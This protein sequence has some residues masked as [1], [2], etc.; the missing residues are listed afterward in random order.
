MDVKEFMPGAAAVEQIRRDLAVYEPERVKAIGRIGWRVPLFLVPVVLVAAWLVIVAW[1]IAP[2]GKQPF[3][4]FLAACAGLAAGGG[5]YGLAR[6]PATDTQ[7]WLRDRILPIAFGF[8][9]D[10]RYG[11][12]VTPTSYSHLPKEVTGRVDRHEFDDVI[13]GRHGDAW[14]EVYECNLAQGYGKNRET[15]FKGV[16]LAFRLDAPFPGKLI[17]TRKLGGVAKWMRDLLGKS[18][19][20]EVTSGD[21]GLEY[22]YEFRTDKPDAAADLLKGNFR[23]ALSWIRDTW[24]G[25]PARV[26]LSG[27]DGFLLLPSTTNFFELPDIG[28]TLDYEAHI[29]PLAAQMASLIATASLLRRACVPSA[30]KEA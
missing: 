24:P 22:E 3:W 1:N 18:D 9:D 14:F 25:E 23:K 5:A 30:D 11:H 4:A 10:L 2:D 20:T 16:V 8:I 17:A 29:R 15:L 7:Q 27:D 13:L 12:E 6:K 21:G 26:A 19:L 28:V